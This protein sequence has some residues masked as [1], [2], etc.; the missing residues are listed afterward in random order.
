MPTAQP[1]FLSMVK[2]FFSI[3]LL[4]HCFGPHPKFEIEHKGNCNLAESDSEKRLRRKPIAENYFDP[5]ALYR[6]ALV[7]HS[8][9]WSWPEHYHDQLECVYIPEGVAKGYVSFD[10]IE[11]GVREGGFFYVPRNKAHGYNL[12]FEEMGS[13]YIAVINR[14]ALITIMSRNPGC[15]RGVLSERLDAIPFNWTHRSSELSPH[16]LSLSDLRKRTGGRQNSDDT[17]ARAFND[18]VHILHIFAFFMNENGSADS[19]LSAAVQQLKR[20]LVDTSDS[21]VSFTEI[22]G[23]CGMSRSYASRLFTREMGI[24]PHEFLTR[25]RIEKAKDR[26]MKSQVNITGAALDSGFCDPSHFSRVFKRYVGV[27][28]KKWI[29][30]QR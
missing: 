7:R 5:C 15:E 24:S 23:Q 8:G 20:K 30:S 21:A 29:A 6:F 2:V 26:L 11:Y 13:V 1:I 17:I 14:E 19:K 18:T 25:K 16:L 9:T 3:L 10:K 12:C 28:P 4:S 27:S 22:A